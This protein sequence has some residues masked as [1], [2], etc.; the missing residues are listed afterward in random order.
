MPALSPVAWSSF[1][2]GL[3]PGGHGIGD[4]I[5]R[6]PETH[7]SAFAI[8]ERHRA[9]AWAAQSGLMLIRAVHPRFRMSRCPFTT[10]VTSTH[11]IAVHVKLDSGRPPCGTL[12]RGFH[13]RTYVHRAL[14]RAVQAGRT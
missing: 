2:A 6:D 14:A 12:G 8:Y 4:F 5:A 3:T 11:R 9:L 1:I 10:H 7:M 13:K